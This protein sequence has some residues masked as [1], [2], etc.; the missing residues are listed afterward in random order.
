MTNVVKKPRRTRLDFVLVL[1]A[2]F[3]LVVL[4]S[5]PRSTNNLLLV[6]ATPVLY[7]IISKLTTNGD[8]PSTAA[9]SYLLCFQ[10]GITGIIL[11]GR[12]ALQAFKEQLTTDAVRSKLN[13]ELITLVGELTPYLLGPLAIGIALYTASSVFEFTASNATH[14]GSALDKLA[15]WLSESQAPEEL[16]SYLAQMFEHF[17]H[18]Q[19]GFKELGGQVV[20]TEQQMRGMQASLN[21]CQSSLDHLASSARSL[22]PDVKQLTNQVA[23]ATSTID[24]LTESVSEIQ[25]VVDD[26]SKIVS[27]RILEL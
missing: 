23:L 2:A 9:R 6:L 5:Q 1:L 19:I 17:E 24:Q 16:K 14:F 3:S 12:E 27:S 11:H 20:A 15:Q 8:L 10:A 18:V 26:L 4:H 21:Q 13:A 22:D 7:L 25:S